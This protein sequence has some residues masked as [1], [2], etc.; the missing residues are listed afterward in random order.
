MTTSSTIRLGVARAVGSS[1][2]FRSNAT[3]SAGAPSRMVGRPRNSRARHDAAAN[4]CSMGIPARRRWPAPRADRPR[5][6]HLVPLRPLASRRKSGEMGCSGRRARARHR[7]RRG[8]A[9]ASRPRRGWAPDL[10]G[11]RRTHVKD[12]RRSLSSAQPRPCRRDCQVSLGLTARGGGGRAHG[13]LRRVASFST[14][15]DGVCPG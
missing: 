15:A 1:S 11:Q 3:R 2:G 14:E 7:R 13:H 12:S 4:A 10:S 5:G 9:G 8:A 6:P